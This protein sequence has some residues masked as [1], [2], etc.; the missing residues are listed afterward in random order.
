M[1]RGLG[2]VKAAVTG[3]KQNEVITGVIGCSAFFRSDCNPA[4]LDESAPVNPVLLRT[5]TPH[6]A[7]MNRAMALYLRITKESAPRNGRLLWKE[8][9]FRSLVIFAKLPTR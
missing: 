2:A 7:M 8:H 9:A 4:Q 5:F 3:A 1:G 6:A